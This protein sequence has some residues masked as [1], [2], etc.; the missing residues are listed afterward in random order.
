MENLAI[1]VLALMIGALLFTRA[2]MLTVCPLAALAIL[3]LSGTAAGKQYL[4]HAAPSIA[5]VFVVMSATQIAIHRILKGGAGDRISVAIASVAAH[6]WL[7]RVPASVLL[8]CIFV[9]AAMLLAMFLHNITAILVLTPLA[10]TLCM[11]YQVR[12]EAMLSA[13]LIS[14]NLGGASMAFGDTPA[15]LQREAWGF[16]PATFAAAMLPRNLVVLVILTAVSAAV[17]WWPVREAKTNWFETLRR[18]RARDDIAAQTQYNGVHKRDALIGWVALT[19]FIGLQFLFPKDA[20]VVGCLVLAGLVLLTR[21]ER[22]LDAYTSLGLEAIVVILSL[23]IVAASVE[24]TPAVQALRHWL[25]THRGVGPIETVAYLL[26]T[27]ISADG[28]AATLVR[29]VHDS[30]QGTMFSAWQL[31]CGICAGS[32][33][34]LTAA[35]AGPII[36]SVSR[37]AGHE[38]TFKAY[39]RFGLPF[40]ALMMGLYLMMN[41]ILGQ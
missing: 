2:G 19:V 29:V 10:V 32:S 27:G 30:N 31:A 24:A 3:V 35:S 13:M 15:I 18:L 41:F 16:T 12:P 8:P 28:S 33:T 37:S 39:S 34:L 36:N 5:T 6:P 22:R 38:L 9:P 14:S 1:L 17:T 4:E 26:T 23:F 25:E 11:R 21:E 7:R 40:S 20:L